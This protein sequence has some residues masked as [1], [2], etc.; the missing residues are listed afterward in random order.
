MADINEHIE[1]LREALAERDTE[2]ERLRRALLVHQDDSRR[3]RRA[4]ELLSER[5]TK[6]ERKRGSS[7]P[8]DWTPRPANLEKVYDAIAAG[9]TTV[10]EASIMSGLS[11]QTCQKATEELRK[12]ERVRR[13]GRTKAGNSSQTVTTYAVMPQAVTDA[14]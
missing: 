11:R 7:Q 1:G 6:R 3:I 12:A 4:L 2:E 13:T 8:H 10:T 5:E 9:A 14:A